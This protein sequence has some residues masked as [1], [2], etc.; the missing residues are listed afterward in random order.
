M[1]PPGNYVDFSDRVFTPDAGQIPH[2][3]STIIQE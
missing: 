1:P 3:L 2:P